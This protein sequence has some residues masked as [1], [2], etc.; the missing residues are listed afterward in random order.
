MGSF[1]TDPTFLLVNRKLQSCT[2]K[3]KY[4]YLYSQ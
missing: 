3:V 4:L 2:M 1:P